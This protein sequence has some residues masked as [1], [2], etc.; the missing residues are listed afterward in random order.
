MASLPGVWILRF[1]FHDTARFVSSRF[2]FKIEVSQ[3]LI[4]EGI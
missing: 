4:C 3:V 1:Y 2:Q